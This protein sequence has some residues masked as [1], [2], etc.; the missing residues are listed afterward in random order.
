[1]LNFPQTAFTEPSESLFSQSMAG[2]F[3]ESK[4]AVIDNRFRQEFVSKSRVLASKV[5]LAKAIIDTLTRGV[6]GSGLR[7]NPEDSVLDILSVTHSL[8]AN[9]SLDLYQLQQQAFSTML[10]SGECWLI[11]QKTEEENYS[12]WFIA[13]PDHVFNPPFVTA[14]EDGTYL[15]RNH[16]LIDGIEFK[17]D[18]TPWAIHY[19]QNPYTADV[20]NKKAWTRI[21]FEDKD[22]VPNILH[23]FVT[24]RPEY[25]RGLPILT[26]LIETLYSL[27]C[28]QQ[29][30]IQ[31]GIVQSCQAL[32][33]KT[34]SNKSLNPFSALSMADLNA[35]LTCSDQETHEHE[36]SKDFSIVPP[37]N[38]NFNGM[39]NQ[40]NYVTPG[41][42]IHLA[43]D[44]TLECVSPTGPSNSLTE[45]YNLVLEQCASCLG[46]PKPV[47]NGLYDASF[48]ASKAAVAQW[49]YTISRFRKS[50]IEQLLKPLYKV[51]LMEY[52]IEEVEAY[53]KAIDSSWRSIDPNVFV[54]E[55]KTM[56]YYA[57]GLQLG[58]ITKDEAAM[59]LFGH[60]ADGV[61]MKEEDD[62][63]M[64]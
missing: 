39:F 55:L 50:F 58:L 42:T 47:L 57:Q 21:F 54:D 41:Q 8:D 31:M 51:Y 45:Y 28:Y 59:T 13:E 12:K 60:K 46:I 11:R 7:L 32:V 16:V 27:Y 22:G 23:L 29:S 44:E 52:G 37:N 56:R 24:D 64:I 15:Y 20:T 33:V 9:H 18:G 19:C 5:P 26:P 2:F 3:S 30:Q 17:S 25:P 40:P 63:F 36:P 53:T 6:I 35:P 34:S 38:R 62:T 14:R 61:E 48:S 1:M 49:N 43:Q 10:L 4:S